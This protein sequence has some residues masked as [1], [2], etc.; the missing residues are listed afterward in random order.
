MA[1]AYVDFQ[2]S[3]AQEIVMEA[4][5]HL[6]ANATPLYAGSS[7]PT[8]WGWL[9]SLKTGRVKEAVADKAEGPQ[10][11]GLTAALPNITSRRKA[12]RIPVGAAIAVAV[13][14]SCLLLAVI[15]AIAKRNTTSN[16][17]RSLSSGGVANR[18][19]SNGGAGGIAVEALA[20]AKKGLGAAG[21]KARYSD[22]SDWMSNG[23][24]SN[25]VG[26]KRYL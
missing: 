12:P 16:K 23:N 15:C 8:E 25:Q 9:V 18:G 2:P 19:S 21:S 13:C 6:D 10:P 20:H 11:L 24:E 4:Q 26:F 14:G 1:L 17:S 7:L 5:E 3:T 22:G